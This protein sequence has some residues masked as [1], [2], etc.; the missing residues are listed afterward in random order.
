MLDADDI[1]RIIGVGAV[2]VGDDVA[3]L[4]DRWERPTPCKAK[5]IVSP[6]VTDE[7]SRLLQACHAVGQPITILG[8]GTGLVGGT[9]SSN[10]EIIVSL[11]RMNRIERI[12]PVNRTAVI[13]A[14]VTIQA[15]QEAAQD[16]GL[17]FG[18]DFGSRSSATIG[19]AIATNAGGNRVLRFGMMRDQVLGLEAV[20][21]DGTVIDAMR[22]LIKDNGG[23]DMKQVFVGTEG[24][25]GIVTRAV[26]RLRPAAA[27]R[28]TA[29]LRIGSFGQVLSLMN[30]LESKLAGQLSA[31][32]VMWETFF[33]VVQEKGRK[34]FRDRMPGAFHVL[35]ESEGSHP[36]ADVDTFLAAMQLGSDQGLIE[37]AVIA[38]SETDRAALWSMRDDI[39]SIFRL[40][41]HIDFDVSIPKRHMEAYCK[42]V[43]EELEALSPQLHAFFFGHIADDNLHLIVSTPTVVSEPLRGQVQNAVYGRVN[44]YA[45]S[46][47]AEHGI[48]LDKLPYMSMGRT[49]E[50]LHLMRLMKRAFD[51]TTILNPGKVVGRI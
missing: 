13:E 3:L 46:I 10:D 49:A 17:S 15:L 50:E 23:Y 18:V 39:D 24:T 11:R 27:S 35:V 6:G 28:N 19:G 7:V 25:L 26:L 51:P 9:V 43:L 33:D 42:T 12:D 14:G 2:I 34:P 41:D 8:G 45:G 29:L 32:E 37:D 30:L 38:S 16:V 22:E 5:A 36:D 31:F 47:S 48:G 21:A 1:V 20:L 4:S 44:A 40:G